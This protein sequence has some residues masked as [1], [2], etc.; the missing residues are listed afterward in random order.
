MVDR[1]GRLRPRAKALGRPPCFPAAMH[2]RRMPRIV[3]CR[4]AD[5]VRLL[6]DG[7]GRGRLER[8][9]LEA[10]KRCRA[11][12]AQIPEAALFRVTL[13]G[14]PARACN[15]RH[16]VWRRLLAAR[17]LPASRPAV[18]DR[19]ANWPGGAAWGAA[20]CAC[21]CGI[22][23]ARHAKVG[24]V[25]RH[26]PL[27]CRR[28]IR[29][30]ERCRLRPAWCMVPPLGGTVSAWQLPGGRGG[31]FLPPGF[32]P[33][34]MAP[35]IGGTVQP[36]DRAAQWGGVAPAEWRVQRTPN[37]VLSL[38]G[39]GRAGL[40]PAITGRRAVR[41]NSAGYHAGRGW[42]WT[43]GRTRPPP[44]LRRRHA[45]TPGRWPRR[46]WCL[47]E[48]CRRWAARFR[49]ADGWQEWCCLSAA[50]AGRPAIAGRQGGG[51]VT[52]RVAGGLGRRRGDE[53]EA[54]SRYPAGAVPRRAGAVPRR[55][56]AGSGGGHGAVQGRHGE[57][58]LQLQ[59]RYMVP[60][61]YPARYPAA[62][63]RPAQSFVP[64]FL[65]ASVASIPLR[66]GFGK[67]GAVPRREARSR[68]FFWR[69]APPARI[70]PPIGGT[71]LAGGNGAALVGGTVYR[72]LE[73]CRQSAARSMVPPCWAARFRR[74]PAE[75]PADRP[76]ARSWG[77]GV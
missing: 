17:F 36:P 61:N 19:P 68:A 35:P 26:D 6:A 21:T 24:A 30:R 51:A 12:P 33:A 40:R 77:G 47:L 11:W 72:R 1:R 64:H 53:W 49:A 4:P 65:A 14:G 43:A 22:R 44:G 16:G 7:F 31:G 27:A 48:R 69:H 56:A 15:C 39:L 66:Q 52:W 73:W 9:S 8:A 60:G 10:R 45:C 25:A 13:S 76:A 50:L 70:V 67:G 32:C 75:P 38:P 37:G 3:T 55:A 63:C 23:P 59:A 29:R 34:G 54:V 41:R 46:V 28:R 57:W 74:R 2:S 20:A 62:P 18:I 58:C 5:A 42:R 71:A